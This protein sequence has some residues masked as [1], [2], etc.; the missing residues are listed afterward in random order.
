MADNVKQGLVVFVPKRPD[1]PGFYSAGEFWPSGPTPV[2]VVA[3]TE[4][5]RAAEAQHRGSGKRFITEA[6]QAVMKGEQE[7]LLSVLTAEDAARATG[8][9]PAAV[10]KDDEERKLLEQHRAKKQAG[11]PAPPSNK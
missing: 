7:G 11:K 9:D 10:A 1:F 3:D 4:A 5:K 2:E 6:Q 8:F